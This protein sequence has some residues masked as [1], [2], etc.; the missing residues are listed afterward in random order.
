VDRLGVFVGD[1][2]GRFFQHP[3][4]EQPADAARYRTGRL[5]QKL[6]RECRLHMSDDAPCMITA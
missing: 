4:Q 1:D 3:E 2:P 6:G 5:P